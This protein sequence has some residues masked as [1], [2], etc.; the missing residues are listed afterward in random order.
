MRVSE[1]VAQPWT[2]HGEGIYSDFLA[3]LLRSRGLFKSAGLLAIG[4][5][6]YHYRRQMDICMEGNIQ[7]IFHR[8]SMFRV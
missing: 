1:Q 6:F 3:I 7:N 8:L 4:F 2:E 5:Y